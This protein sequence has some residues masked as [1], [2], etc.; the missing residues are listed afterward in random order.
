MEQGS[1]EMA[2]EHFSQALEINPQLV[3]AERNLVFLVDEAVKGY[4]RVLQSTPSNAEMHNNLGVLLLR[5]GEVEE[6]II[7]FSKALSIDPSYRTAQENLD[8]VQSERD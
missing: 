3:D 6:A 4:R 1:V 8:R 5:K 7:H 2:I